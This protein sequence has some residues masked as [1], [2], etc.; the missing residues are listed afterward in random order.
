MTGMARKLFLYFQQ[1]GLL[2]GLWRIYTKFRLTGFSCKYIVSQF[3]RLKKQSTDEGVKAGHFGE[4]NFVEMYPDDFLASKSSLPETDIL[5]IDH[6]LGGGAGAFCVQYCNEALREGKTILL[7]RF[8][9]RFIRYELLVFGKERNLLI[10]T[11]ASNQFYALL[12]KS[13]P[14]KIFV[15]NIVSWPEPLVFLSWLGRVAKAVPTEIY[16]HDFFCIC[17]TI[18]LLDR[19]LHFCDLPDNPVQCDVCLRRNLFAAPYAPKAIGPWR[20]AW[21]TVLDA[22]SVLW[23]GHESVGKLLERVYPELRDKFRVFPSVKLPTLKKY[24]KTLSVAI[25]QP[26]T[27]AVI[28]DIMILKGA[29]IVAALASLLEEEDEKFRLVVIGE[30]E[31]PCK[32]PNLIVTGRY[33]REDLPVLLEKHCVSIC[34]VPSI[35]PETY[36]YVMDEIMELDFPVVSFPIGAQG[37]KARAYKF[38]LCA[39]AISAE[40]CLD[41]IKHLLVRTKKIQEARA[42]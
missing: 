31:I 12:E 18:V 3:F 32:S 37:W 36:S 21:R 26:T 16:V 9:R 41:A 42:L 14:K 28:G 5:V 23:E 19:S 10:A 20:D 25:A 34:L 13:A 7:A 27:I 29:L 35:C 39:E 6:D 2:H 17:P 24:S 1:Y 38:G 8:D 15:N 30:L 33:Q 22:A 40:S 11:D 4:K